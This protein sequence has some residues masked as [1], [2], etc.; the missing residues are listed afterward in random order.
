MSSFSTYNTFQRIMCSL[1]IVKMYY[2]VTRKNIMKNRSFFTQN[3]SLKKKKG[4]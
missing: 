4:K 1:E 3:K 2:N